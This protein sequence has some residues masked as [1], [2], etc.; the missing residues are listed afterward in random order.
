MEAEAPETEAREAE[1]KEEAEAELEHERDSEPRFKLTGGLKNGLV[2]VNRYYANITS[3][4]DKQLAMDLI[5]GLF[6]PSKERPAI[7][8]FDLQPQFHRTVSGR[9]QVA[10]QELGEGG[11]EEGTKGHFDPLMLIGKGIIW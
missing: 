1:A 3:D 6:V 10:K 7:W 9:Y 4:Y 5:L 11:E 8:E 2:A